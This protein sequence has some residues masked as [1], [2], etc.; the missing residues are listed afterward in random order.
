[1]D[2]ISIKKAA[3]QWGVSE[4]VARKYCRDRRVPGA[5]LQNGTWMIPANAKK[6]AKLVGRRPTEKI[7]ALGKKL[8]S[9]RRKKNPHGLYDYVMINFTYSSC[10]M[11]SN[12]LTR[13]QIEDIY[14]KGKLCQIFEP[15]KV[16]DMVEA[17]N[18]CVCIDYILDHAG[19]P[20]SHKLIMQLHY[21]LMFGTVDH[22]KKLVKPGVYRSEGVLRRNRDVP[23]AEEI[24]KRLKELIREYEGSHEIGMEEIL[25]FHV[26]FEQIVPFEDGNGRVGRLIMFKECLR[27][28]VTPF[29]I[30]DKRRT[31]YLAGL[32]DWPDY[33]LTLIDVA[34]VAQ[35]RFELQIAHQKL[36]DPRWSHA[37]DYEENDDEEEDLC[38]EQFE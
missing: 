23:P 11:A 2:Y 34:T 31:Q 15:T 18:H 19:E 26:R 20:L 33:R 5:V 36:R 28:D 25:D 9:Q 10:R 14:R 6:P 37:E 35:E 4:V 27:Q 3:D 38:N 22:R 7:S 12:R 1:M 24:D 21:L 13:N 30:D 29:I 17:M 8:R 16:S 32:K